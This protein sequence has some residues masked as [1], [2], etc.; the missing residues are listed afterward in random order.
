M[1]VTQPLDVCRHCHADIA[2][3]RKSHEGLGF[4]TCESSGCH[5]FHDNR[6]LHEDYL[7][8]HLG[9]PGW[10]LPEGR[11]PS[12]AS[13]KA[14]REPEEEQKALSAAEH[15]AP[16]HAAGDASVV[17]DWAATAHANAGV[18]CSGCHVPKGEKGEDTWIE[19]PGIDS[20]KSCHDDEVAGFLGGKHGMRTAAGLSPLHPGMAQLPMQKGAQQELSCTSCHAE[21]R[22][23]RK[24][25]AVDA[26]LSCHA[27][28]HSLAYRQSKH[29]TLFKQE[30]EGRAPAGS[31]VSCATCHL[32]RV[33]RLPGS[34]IE[35]AH[36]QN[37]FLRP[38]DKQIDSV[39]RHCH[40]VE[41]AIDA[42]ADSAVIARGVDGKPTQH[43]RSMDMVREKLRALSRPAPSH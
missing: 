2:T 36:N 30:L 43:V 21:H 11:V 40:S 15:D 1:G 32:P 12:R 35:V 16:A 31:G 8:K 37:D 20:C 17:S 28:S 4:D 18:N 10:L 24:A 27:D 42:L 33:A 26:C 23:D 41:F 3:E 39:C 29:Y 13:E 9:E 6:A 7:E 14:G 22:F 19:R 5:N 25:A 38:N 34:P